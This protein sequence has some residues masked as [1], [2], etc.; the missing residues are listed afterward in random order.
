M[1]DTLNILL[2][3]CVNDLEDFIEHHGVVGMKWG[4]RRQQR[5]AE[6]DKRIK[7]QTEHYRK[8]L[9]TNNLADAYRVFGKRGVKKISAN[10]DR[11]YTT[12]EAKA[13]EIRRQDFNRKMAKTIINT[14]VSIATGIAFKKFVYPK[15]APKIIEGFKTLMKEKTSE[16]F[17]NTVTAVVSGKTMSYTNLTDSNGNIIKSYDQDGLPA[18]SAFRAF[19]DTRSK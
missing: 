11:G 12:D 10:V 9:K 2:A 18:G 5:R 6:R 15:V 4:V 13:M 14:T 19:I 7:E 8:N 1:Q 16:T 3:P 17:T